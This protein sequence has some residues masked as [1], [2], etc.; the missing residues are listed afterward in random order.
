VPGI[1]KLNDEFEVEQTVAV[2]TLK[3]ELVAVGKAKMM[4]KDIMKEEKG[5]AVNIHK[6]FMEPGTYP[7][8]EKKA[9]IENK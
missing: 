7:K 8:V 4:P 6:V 9:N 2:M 5:I 3:D 1:A